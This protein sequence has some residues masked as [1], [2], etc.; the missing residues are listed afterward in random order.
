MLTIY[1]LITGFILDL[2]L[3]DPIWLPHPVRFIGLLISSGEKLLAKLN[4]TTN[5]GK[6]VCGM[7]L[8]VWVVAVSF[9]IPFG[10]LYLLGTVSAGLK[11]IVEALMCY[12]ILATK[13]L[14]IESMKVYQ[15]LKKGDLVK[16]RE[17]LSRIVS[18]DTENLSYAKTAKGAVETVA[19][20]TSDGVIAPMLYILIGG[21]P[22]GFLY[23]GINTLDSMI[24]YK[25]EK[26]LYFGK[27][28]ARLDDV[29]NYIPA[30]IS[31]YIMLIAAFFA[32]LDFNNAIRIF[33]RDRHNHTSPNSAYTEA[34]CAGALNIQLAGSSSYFGKLVEKPTI[35]DAIR[36]IEAED[37]KRANRLLYTTAIWGLLI[38]VGVRALIVFLL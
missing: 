19:E 10:L 21:A 11:F 14:K 3:G 27:F 23:K 30:R 16:A 8:S 34:V 31:A 20:N 2:I 25:N 17:Y 29:A 18:R 13:A 24:G 7:V 12:Q 32:G 35:G 22:L 6:F 38:G 28:A 1:A 37:I 9:L 15:E 5:P 36:E 4:S 33:H 26:Y